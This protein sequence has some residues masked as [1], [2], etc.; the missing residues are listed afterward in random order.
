MRT[1]ILFA[2]MMVVMACSE[3]K[4]MGAAEET[5]P[6]DTTSIA[7]RSDTKATEPAE[8]D[9]VTAATN[10]ANSPTFNGV[11]MVSPQRMATLS[12]TL[13]GKIHTLT[14]MPGQKVTC[15]Q[16][17]ATIDNPAFIE[18][19]QAYLEACAQTEYLEREYQRQCAL[20]EEDATS[21]KRV[22]QSKAEYMS[23]KSRLAASESRL[24]TL[25][26]NPVSL[27]EKGIMDYLPVTSP[28]TGYVTNVD[29]NI[30]KYLDAGEPIC[31]VIDKRAPLLQLT[32]YEKELSQMRTGRRVLFRV[33]G[34]G[35]QSFEAKVVSIDQSI[36]E[37]D[38]SVKVYAQV[39]TAHND[40]RPGMYVR[41]K[42]L[43]A[44]GN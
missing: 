38:Y 3:Q 40:F 6:K 1:K 30:G 32:V 14:V 36:D 10:V 34:M 41:A 4:P 7:E 37:K 2:S 25:G 12:L 31:D 42:L 27:Q 43:D 19:Q 8:A 20:G 13:G 33:N 11:I 15:G 29:V 44:E 18:L 17:V 23:M 28:L 22:Q 21:R 35:T 24:R 5:T 9:V 26:I 39:L 16:V